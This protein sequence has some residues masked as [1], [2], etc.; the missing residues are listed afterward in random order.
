MV[1]TPV[2]KRQLSDIQRSIITEKINKKVKNQ[3]LNATMF[4]DL[5]IIYH[6]GDITNA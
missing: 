4:D 6:M 2:L 1:E 5:S 3:V